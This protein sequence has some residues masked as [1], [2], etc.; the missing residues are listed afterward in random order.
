MV[1]RALHSALLTFLLLLLAVPAA[2]AAEADG[3][4]LT[5]AQP[6]P[7]D[8][9][10]TI[11]RISLAFSAPLQVDGAHAIRLN[12]P[13]G[14]ALADGVPEVFG[15][16]EVS[17]PVDVALRGDGTYTVQWVVIAADG[18]RVEDSYTIDVVGSGVPATRPGG[19]LPIG[20]GIVPP[21]TEADLAGN[22]IG[23]LYL[24]ALGVI[25]LGGIITGIVLLRRPGRGRDD[26]DRQQ[27]TTG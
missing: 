3:P 19:P 17:L 8:E 16:L 6:G 5:S 25:V 14:T 22:L 12:A 26:F 7:G 1:E 10:E 15:D 2:R 11:D 18:T 9:V 27:G 20:S 4:T 13:D 24:G 23:P 21:T